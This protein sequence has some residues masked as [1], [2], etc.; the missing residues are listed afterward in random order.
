MDL[1]LFL[2]GLSQIAL[3]I[4]SLAIPRVLGWRQETAKLDRLTRNVFWTYAGYIWAFNVS[5]GLVSSI[6]PEWL[7]EGSPLSRAVCMFIAL[8]WGAR[9]VIQF[10]CFGKSAPAGLRFKMAEVALVSLFVCLT[11]VYSIIAI[12]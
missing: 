10:T 4:A 8:Y 5:F 9:V 3:A 6:K 2:A 7:L 11:G 1:L 12:F